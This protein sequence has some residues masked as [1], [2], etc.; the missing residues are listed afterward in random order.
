MNSKLIHNNKE[1]PPN[2][3]ENHATG[4]PEKKTPPLMSSPN[5]GN[6]PLRE[7]SDTIKDHRMQ[8]DSPTKT[9]QVQLRV[10]SQIDESLTYDDG[11]SESEDLDAVMNE[12]IGQVYCGNQLTIWDL[13]PMVG[14]EMILHV[15]KI[16]DTIKANP[17]SR[18]GVL[19]TPVEIEIPKG[20]NGLTFAC[21]HV[22]LSIEHQYSVANC[23]DESKPQLL[24]DWLSELL[25]SGL[26]AGW[27]PT[28][29]SQDKRCRVEL[30]CIS[31]ANLEISKNIAQAIFD[32]LRTAGWPIYHF[33]SPNVGN[34]SIMT[35]IANT[36]ADAK[37]LS[38]PPGKLTSYLDL[39]KA[40]IAKE[41]KS[42]G[43]RASV[44]AAKFKHRTRQAEVHRTSQRPAHS[45][46]P[47]TSLYHG[48]QTRL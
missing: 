31:D 8:L 18:P 13:K 19:T 29:C 48:C 42:Q 28:P 39:R 38:K 3:E 12:G 16:L 26:N 2:A 41:K 35:L 45:V 43:A 40:V 22:C 9:S 11:G 6:T 7:R 33:W 44:D 10:N 1:N 14:S 23:S 25:D 32:E 20:R 17:K 46:Y 15:Q 4:F 36:V 27:S 24:D 30:Q 21:N 37:D 5:A 34:K 47:R